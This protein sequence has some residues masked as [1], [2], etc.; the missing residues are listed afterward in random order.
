MTHSRPDAAGN[1][2]LARREGLT[3]ICSMHEGVA[4]VTWA[5]LGCFR[6][7][8]PYVIEARVATGFELNIVT[9]Q[10]D[11]ANDRMNDPNSGGCL[12]YTG[13]VS[14]EPQSFGAKPK[15]SSPQINAA[16]C[17]DSESGQLDLNCVE[18]RGILRSANSPIRSFPKLLSRKE[19]SNRAVAVSE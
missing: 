4:T 2:F 6:V 11:I 3:Q 12:N 15:N 19:L 14:K 18:I 5:V 10:Q 16:S 8:L 13:G 17:S 9:Q 7:P 1:F